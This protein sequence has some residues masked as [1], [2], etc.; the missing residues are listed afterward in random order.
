MDHGWAHRRDLNVHY[1]HLVPSTPAE[2]VLVVE[3]FHTSLILLQLDIQIH[4]RNT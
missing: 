2:N 4:A 3:P 1:Q